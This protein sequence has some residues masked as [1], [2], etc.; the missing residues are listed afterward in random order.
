M[1]KGRCA[2]MYGLW[3]Y[4][5]V[6]L[7]II[8]GFLTIFP[9]LVL[10]FGSFWGAPL[11]A[12]GSFSLKGY[13]NVFYNTTETYK[14]FYNSFFI[15]TIKTILAVIVG[16][17]L[18]W[19][20][21]RTDTPGARAL[22]ILVGL[23]FFIPPILT[24][25]AWAM[26]G[27]PNTG[28]LNQW[29]MMLPW[30]D[31]PPIN[32]YSVGGIIWH[33]FQYSSAFMFMMILPAFRTMDPSLEE[34]SRMSGANNILTMVKITFPLLRPAILGAAILTFIRGLESFESPTFF[35]MPANIFVIT[36]K[37]YANIIDSDPPKYAEAMALSVAL[38]IV[39]F[40]I[41]AIQR[42]MLSKR[43]YVTISGK[44]YQPRLIKLGRAKWITF[45]LCILYFIVTVALPFSQLILS[46]FF[47]IFGFYTRE[48]FTLN[49]YSRVLQ[50]PIVWRALKN[51]L[52]LGGGAAIIAVSMSTLIA[53]FVHRTKL[54]G[55]KA[56]DFISWL[57]WMV[58]GTLLGLGMLWGYI[59]LP[60]P[61]NFYGTK[62][63][64]LLAY[65]TIGLPLATRSMSGIMVQ[66]G[67]D[68]EECSRVHGASRT[69]TFIYVLAT[70][71]RPGY[72]SALLLLFFITMREL[73]ASILLYSF[74]NEVMP[75]IIL[76]YW[77]GGGSEVVSVIAI[78]M[79]V[80]AIIFRLLE[81]Y[82]TKASLR[83]QKKI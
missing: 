20:V 49:N 51:T 72:V 14:V 42:R 82:V 70:L 35:G 21:T 26:L 10:V 83:H 1:P 78:L 81:L 55:R 30:I 40:L 59:L 76:K 36:T 54:K 18:A 22:E 38:M 64:L 79:L 44:G 41:V 12:I 60:E 47:K 5:Y 73:S 43:E 17:F 31:K 61:F 53:Y 37:I 11:G 71:I 33:M 23:P 63:I 74:G 25:L 56:L 19:V 46:S 7:F 68:L 13:I 80:I 28:L 52:L 27:N 50:D 34:S 65:V 66:I 24:A 8:V 4:V 62:W 69:Q 3:K 9:I 29:L 57:P 75:V 16:G 67:P 48:M 32:L 39:S 58:P 2:G 15:A 6:I 77:Q 45:A